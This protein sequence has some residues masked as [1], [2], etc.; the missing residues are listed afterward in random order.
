MDQFSMKDFRSEDFSSKACDCTSNGNPEQ[1]P[2][3]NEDIGYWIIAHWSLIRHWN[4]AGDSDQSVT[5]A[6]GCSMRQV[7]GP[8]AQRMWTVKN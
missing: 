6:A 1:A 3:L 7:M 2:P 8:P 5:S 4:L